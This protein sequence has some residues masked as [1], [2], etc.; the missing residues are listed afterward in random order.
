MLEE[1]K[2]RYNGL[3]FMHLEELFNSKCQTQNNYHQTIT[4]AFSEY[5]SKF[6]EV[7]I[8]REIDP[9]GYAQQLKI[10][11]RALLE[12]NAKLL[13]KKLLGI[14]TRLLK[15]TY[16]LTHDLRQD[17]RHVLRKNMPISIDE[18]KVNSILIQKTFILMNVQ[19]LQKLEFFKSLISWIKR[20]YLVS[21]KSCFS[22][23]SYHLKINLL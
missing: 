6:C 17:L 19:L 12:V 15:S 23:K 14:L 11:R 18:E 20:R 5:E 16:N 2:N 7:D 21:L 10:K 3:A 9:V 8:D 13:K 22:K 4:Y 1:V